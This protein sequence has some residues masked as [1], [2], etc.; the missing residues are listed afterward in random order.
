MTPLTPD[1]DAALRYFETPRKVGQADPER[2]AHL[3]MLL[4]R[5]F[6]VEHEGFH[7]SIVTR[8]PANAARRTNS[9]WVPV[10]A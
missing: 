9:N 3:P 1:Q 7:I 2:A 5:D 8:P 10:A 4:E 6:I